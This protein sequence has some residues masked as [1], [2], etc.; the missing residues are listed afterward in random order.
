MGYRMAKKRGGQ[1]PKSMVMLDGLMDRLLKIKVF[2]SIFNL[3]KI[4]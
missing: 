4:K 2:H 3:T 1:N